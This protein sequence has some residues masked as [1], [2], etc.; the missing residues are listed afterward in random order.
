MILNI[1]FHQFS[2]WYMKKR[3]YDMNLPPNSTLLILCIQVIPESPPRYVAI[4][5][6]K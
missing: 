3:G 2:F 6:P 5:L 1:V 4:K